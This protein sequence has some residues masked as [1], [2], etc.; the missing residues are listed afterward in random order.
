MVLSV[1]PRVIGHHDI[2]IEMYHMTLL[3][4]P[5]LQTGFVLCLKLHS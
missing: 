5:Q 4:V 3:H 1:V 2:A